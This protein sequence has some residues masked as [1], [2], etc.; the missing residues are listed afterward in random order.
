MPSCIMPRK[1]SPWYICVVVSAHYFG[2][3]ISF[4][5]KRGMR[6]ENWRLL[7]NSREARPQQVPSTESKIEGSIRLVC[8]A[9]Q[10]RWQEKNFQKATFLGRDFLFLQLFPLNLV[11]PSFFSPLLL[12]LFL[13][14]RFTL[15]RFYCQ[16]FFKP[17]SRRWDHGSW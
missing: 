3:E 2:N 8:P 4:R 7:E 10:V 5:Q 6:Q 15:E 16:S 11:T 1:R 9:Y 17:R 14:S 12:F 13:G